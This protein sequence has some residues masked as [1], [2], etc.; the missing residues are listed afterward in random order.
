YT[1]GVQPLSPS[2]D[3]IDSLTRR[4]EALESQWRLDRPLRPAHRFRLVN[5]TGA[6]L[7]LRFEPW[8]DRY[9]VPAGEEREVVLRGPEGECAEIEPGAAEVV[10]HGWPGARYSVYREDLRIGFS[11]RPA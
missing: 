3:P 8:G 4:V 10:I 5:P 6:S 7:T 9:E 1:H 2:A 11:R